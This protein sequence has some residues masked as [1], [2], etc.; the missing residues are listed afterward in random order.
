M[1]SLLS[2]QLKQAEGLSESGFTI[3]MPLT[4]YSLIGSL[5]A[6]TLVTRSV[7]DYLLTNPQIKAIVPWTKLTGAKHSGGGDRIVAYVRDPMV[8]GALVPM[9]FNRLPPQYDGLEVKV[10]C[11]SRCGGT[12]IRYPVA[13]LYCDGV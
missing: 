13:M 4:H 10:P 1:V 7:L 11:W 6:S 5:P 8:L 9:N 2:G 12:V 3:A